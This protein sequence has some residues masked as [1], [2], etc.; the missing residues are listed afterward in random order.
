MNQEFEDKIKKRVWAIEI[1]LIIA[2]IAYLIITL[3]LKIFVVLAFQI[4]LMT[5]LVVFQLVDT[6]L[7]PYWLGQLKNL[8][9][10]RKSAYQKML[11]LALTG[12]VCLAVFVFS[13]EGKNST[14]GYSSIGFYFA[15]GYILL[16]RL[17]HKER[18][19]FLG[20]EDEDSTEDNES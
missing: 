15:L 17:K 8:Q 12:I 18:R 16:N 10:E 20:I 4:I 6:V 9:P 13:M 7:Q 5:F 2:I 19:K 14:T 1:G 11:L 3:Y